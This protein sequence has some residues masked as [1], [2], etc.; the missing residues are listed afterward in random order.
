MAADPESKPRRKVQR[1]VAR[2]IVTPVDS[3]MVCTESLRVHRAEVCKFRPASQAGLL[4]G[5]GLPGRVRA[6]Y[7]LPTSFVVPRYGPVNRR[8]TANQET[9]IETA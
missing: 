8:C 7:D 2:S 1:A 4:T 5:T 6:T 3:E 9:R